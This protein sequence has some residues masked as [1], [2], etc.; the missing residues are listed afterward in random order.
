[1]DSSLEYF[2]AT[3]SRRNKRKEKQSKIFNKKYLNEIRSEINQN[4][5]FPTLEAEEIKV[6]KE[7]IRKERKLHQWKER[8]VYVIVMVILVYVFFQLI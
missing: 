3:I 4:L 8:I 6:L 2:K 7:K 5:D 1:M